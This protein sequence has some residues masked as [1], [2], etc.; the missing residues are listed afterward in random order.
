MS[1]DKPLIVCSKHDVPQ[2]AALIELQ[3]R[4]QLS[5]LAAATKCQASV[6]Y[7]RAAHRLSDD[8]LLEAQKVEAEFRRR[9]ARIVN[10]IGNRDRKSVV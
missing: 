5:T 4:V 9:G 7:M 10:S 3:D 6:V 8:E 1:A 2:L